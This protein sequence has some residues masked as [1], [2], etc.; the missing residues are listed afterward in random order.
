MG[1]R[2]GRPAPTHGPGPLL[3]R[4][5]AARALAAGAAAA[6]GAGAA[7]ASGPAERE[8][9]ATAATATLRVSVVVPALNEEAVLGDTLRA[10]RGLSPAPAEVIVCAGP[11]TDRTAA[12]A[13]EYGAKVISGGPKGRARQMNAGAK[14]ATGDALLFLHA[15]T[16]PPADVVRVVSRV[17]ADWRVVGGGFASLIT[18]PERTLW[19]MSWHNVA[20]THYAPALFLPFSYARGLRILFGDQAIFCRASDFRRVG[21][22]D[23]RL[24]IMEDADLCIR[25][26]GEGA[27]SPD[28]REAR[29]W[30]RIRLVDRVV[31]TDGRRF[32]A[33][34]LNHVKATA[35]HFLLAFSWF[36]GAS[37]ERLHT[38]KD[39]F[40]GDVR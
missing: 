20:K 36:F 7:G 6:V 35:V 39:R 25:L 19:G 37:P 11:S 29:D 28:G 30:G 16:L 22:Y 27:R 14:A 4:R 32:D 2:V 10:L 3:R 34:H 40:Y 31:H 8:K 21:G 24:P 26:H 38:L 5:L 17:L 23:E 33:W 9:T 12:I 15:D 18:L 13:R 1:P